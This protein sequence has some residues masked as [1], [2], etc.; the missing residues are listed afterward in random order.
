MIVA[1]QPFWR[2]RRGQESRKLELGGE[3]F[4]GE[5]LSRNAAGMIVIN[6]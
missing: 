5:K 1:A 3:L 2:L 4:A 6:R